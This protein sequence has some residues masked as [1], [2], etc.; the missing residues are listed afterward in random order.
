MEHV[1]HTFPPVFDARSRVLIVG[2]LPSV[3]SRE[4]GFY[5]GNPRNRFFRVVS[6]LLHMPLPRSNEEKREL[7]LAGR[8]AVFD[9][10]AECDIMGSSDASIKN[11]RPNDFSVIFKT[12]DIRQIFANG[13]MAHKYYTKYVG[14]AV[15][16]PSTSPANAAYS[17]ERLTGA[18]S[19]ICP[20]LEQ[21]DKT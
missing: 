1:V 16:L 3:Q 6:M 20:Y 9:A 19:V 12:A 14:E 17:L 8:I 10:I 18:W 7:L 11:V 5:Y 13:G 4:E 2:S 21:F 15:R